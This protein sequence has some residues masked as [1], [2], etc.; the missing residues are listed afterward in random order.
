MTQPPMTERPIVVGILEDDLRLQERLAQLIASHARVGRILCFSD[1]HGL[2]TSDQIDVL[3]VLFADLSL[4]DGSSISTI[5][6]FCERKPDALVIIVSSSSDSDTVIRS[7]Q[8]G[9]VGY[10]FKDDTSMEVTRGLSLAL[11]GGAPISPS[12]ARKILK[13]F[14]SVEPPPQTATFLTQREVEV[15][16]ILAKGFSYKESAALLGISE[17]TLPVHVRNI[18]RKLNTTNKIEA[19]H[20]ARL[21]GLIR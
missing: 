15:L 2:R 20:E 16:E 6:W 12:I 5:T 17:K 14:H 18:Y 13:T 19:I 8:A 4:P 21:M 9:A 10:L 1:N 7:I 3:D 11:E